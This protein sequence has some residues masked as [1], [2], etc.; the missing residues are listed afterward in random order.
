M[1]GVVGEVQVLWCRTPCAWHPTMPLVQQACHPN[2]HIH[3]HTRT[4]AENPQKQYYIVLLC[5]ST[6]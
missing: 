4:S 2:L 3:L 6:R 1:V 5:I